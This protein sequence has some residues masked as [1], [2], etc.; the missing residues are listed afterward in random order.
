[1]L[2]RQGSCF[3]E[4][5]LVIDR[6][7]ETTLKNQTR[8]KRATTK[9][10]FVIDANTNFRSISMKDLLS[11]S[12]TKTDLIKFLSQKALEYSRQASLLK[13][14]VTYDTQTFGNFE[15]DTKLRTHSQEE[16]DTL[17]ILHAST[18]G[19]DFNV[20]VDSP[21]TDLLMLLIHTYTSHGKIAGMCHFSNRF[22]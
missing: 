8:E 4:I 16:A 17:I 1:M 21:D 2:L 13:K 7:L 6:Y 20:A 19:D 10:Q 22:Y 9:R 12:K 18:F 11:N 3:D 5:H 15:I 14:F